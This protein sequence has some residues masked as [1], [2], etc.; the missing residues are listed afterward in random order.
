MTYTGETRQYQI[1]ILL[2]TTEMR[3]LRKKLRVEFIVVPYISRPYQ[4]HAEMDYG[5][6]QEPSYI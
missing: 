1:Q 2:D 6:I 4:R 5:Q 3:V